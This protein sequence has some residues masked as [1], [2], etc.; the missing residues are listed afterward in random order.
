[1]RKLIGNDKAIEVHE[2]KTNLDPRYCWVDAWVFERVLEQIE[3]EFKGIE[4][5]KRG[6]DEE[7]RLIQLAEKAIGIY[8][9]HFLSADEGYLWTTSFRER[10]RTKFF[11]LITRLG[12]YM[13]K[14]EQWEKAIEY[15]QRA[16]EIDDLAEEFYQQLMI[17]Y[18]HLGQDGKAVETYRRCKKTLSAALGL[19]P[20]PKT[21][22]IYKTLIG[23]AK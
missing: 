14:R 9:G 12:E 8:R 16:L 13:Q 20:S 15:Y 19:E 10:L 22:A 23:N 11:R 3:A 1:L 21:Q 17:C 2:G 18:R 5:E 4:H 6:E 7:K